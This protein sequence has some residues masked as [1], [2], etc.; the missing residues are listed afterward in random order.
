MFDYLWSLHAFFISNGLFQLR[1]KCRLA[2]L[3]TF[4]F[5]WTPYPQ[6]CSNTHVLVL[7]IVLMDFRSVF[8]GFGE[9][10][11]VV[12]GRFLKHFHLCFDVFSSLLESFS[13]R[14]LGLDALGNELS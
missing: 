9:D 6:K 10:V 4:P 3:R 14:R 2:K 12:W 7:R 1:L 11:C 5:R 13:S 8:D